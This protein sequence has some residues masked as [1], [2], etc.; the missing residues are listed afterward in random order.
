MPPRDPSPDPFPFRTAALAEATPGARSPAES[1]RCASSYSSR[2]WSVTQSRAKF[3]SNSFHLAEPLPL[4]GRWSY[5]GGGGGQVRSGAGCPRGM[6]V[7]HEDLAEIKSLL[8]GARST[9]DV[10][11]A[12]ALTEVSVDELSLLHISEPTRPY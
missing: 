8:A 9:Q 1:A 11:P 2:S 7:L 3:P 5:S 6:S 12:M 4:R 10:F